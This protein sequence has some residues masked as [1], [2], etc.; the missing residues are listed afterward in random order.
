MK[1]SGIISCQPTKFKAVS[2]EKNYK[3]IIEF[4]KNV[5]YQGIELAIRNPQEINIKEIKDISQK[6]SMPVVAIGTGQA[7]FEEGLSLSSLD[8][9]IRKKSVE[10][11]KNQISLAVEFNAQVIIGLIR[12]MLDKEKP[13]E[14]RRVFLES[15]RDCDGF[16]QKNNIILAIEPINR[17]ETNFINNLS[18]AVCFIKESKGKQLRILL[19]TFHMNIEEKNLI[20]AVKK[21]KSFLSHFHVADSNRYAPGKGHI[22]F[23]SVIESLK[24]INYQ[25]FVSPEILPFPDFKKSIK[26]SYSHIFPLIDKK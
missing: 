13:L 15:L 7:Y 24:E 12:G 2:F 20:D 6:L 1:I 16:A 4:L 25:G 8:G 10:R 14:S 21:S 17:Y 11:I 9:K 18:E 23:S 3:K 19:D 5:G 26:Q 22:N